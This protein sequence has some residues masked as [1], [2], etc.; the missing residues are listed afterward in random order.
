[1]YRFNYVNGF[2]L[3][4]S[5]LVRKFQ[6]YFLSSFFLIYLEILKAFSKID[7]LIDRV[8]TLR[9]LPNRVKKINNLR[10]SKENT[11]SG[12]D[13]EDNDKE[14]PSLNASDTVSIGEHLIDFCPQNLISTSLDKS[15]NPYSEVFSIEDN[16][17]TFFNSFALQNPNI[18]QNRIMNDQ[19][20]PQGVNN[21]NNNADNANNGN[22]NANNYNLIRHVRFPNRNEIINIIK[23][24][25]PD[26]RGDNVEEFVRKVDGFIG[27]IDQADLNFALRYILS[28]IKGSA[29]I[30]IRDR[31]YAT[32]DE[33]KESL[34][35]KFSNDSNSNY[36]ND[37]S[38]CRQ[39]S[40][41]SVTDYADRVYIILVKKI[42]LLNNPEFAHILRR[43]FTQIFLSGLRS[44]IWERIRL[45]QAPTDLD[46]AIRMA[47]CEEHDILVMN[48]IRS[49]MGY[50]QLQPN[51][52]NTFYPNN[53]NRNN[54]Y[55]NR[56]NFN[57]DRN[58]FNNN[59]NNFNND[60]NNYNNNRNNFNNDRN[61]FNNNRNNFNSDQNNFNNN[62]NNFNNQSNFN[63]GNFY[64]NRNNFKNNSRNFRNSQPNQNNFQ[65]QKE[66][67]NSAN[68]QQQQ[69][70]SGKKLQE[71][72]PN[73]YKNGQNSQNFSNQNY[74][75]QRQNFTPRYQNF[76]SNDSRPPNRNDESYWGLNNPVESVQ[77]SNLPQICYP[78][79]CENTQSYLNVQPIL[80]SNVDY[81]QN[82]NS[83]SENFSGSRFSPQPTVTSLNYLNLNRAVGISGTHTFSA[84]QH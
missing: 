16:E 64:N 43:E 80:N 26:F 2:Q 84:A 46:E 15:K 49:P 30:R 42:H 63:R 61:Y 73:F 54:N 51:N 6:F 83:L 79:S 23:D 57:K 1:M 59:R 77:A 53:N 52:N 33:P 22:N 13:I 45:R 20:N 47:R 34:L 48:E 8:L 7:K 21:G 72:Q 31:E 35:L 70:Y 58:Y 66:N 41:E 44:E 17:R 50:N 56:N 11:P 28:K 37:Y 25:T 9:P 14:T 75:Q 67:N 29:E 65:F 71:F 82:S 60:P 69:N 18:Q 4:D 78:Q 5:T 3:C 38:V 40:N 36:H 76:A 24:L 68:F 39:F 81:S 74:Q 27:D 19:A 62:R 32:W 55:N 12:S 10:G